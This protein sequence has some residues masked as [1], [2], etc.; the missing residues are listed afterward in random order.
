MGLEANT[1]DGHT[2]I[3]EVR[4][5]RK[6][7][8][9]FGAVHVLKIEVIVT[10]L[11]IGIGCMRRLEGIFD[12]G[13]ANHILEHIATPGPIFVEGFIDHIPVP[14][15]ALEMGH[16]SRN[17]VIHGRQERAAGGNIVDPTG[18]LAV[19]D[20]R[21][22]ANLHAMALSETHNRIRRPKV[23]GALGGFSGLPLHLIARSHPIEL[24]LGNRRIRVVAQ[25]VGF[26]GHTNGPAALRPCLGQRGGG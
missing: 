16:F 21:M 26:D 5:H 13:V 18:E 2:T 6:H 12:I 20:Q 3:F 9:G 4:H 19:P 14:D 15:A 10:Q 7:C 24:G 8:L 22:A 23:K 25:Q 11:G 1:V 17:V